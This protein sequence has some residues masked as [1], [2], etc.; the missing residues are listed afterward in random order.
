MRLQNSCKVILALILLCTAAWCADETAKPA[1]TVKQSDGRIDVN[2]ADQPFAAYVYKDEKI[3]RPY[4]TAVHAPNGVQVTRNHP[5][6][7]GQDDTDHDTMHP[8]IWQAFGDLGGADFWR[9]KA[10]VKHQGFVVEP[11]A[12]PDYALFTVEN[13]YVDGEKLIA[14]EM[15]RY[16]LRVDELGYY[17]LIDSTFFDGTDAFTFGD[18]EEMGLGVRVA[19]PMAVKNGGTLLNSEGGKDEA[20]V[21]GKSAAWCDYS[22]VIDGKPVGITLMPNPANF[23]PSWFHARDYGFFAANP[24]GRNAM[25]GGE[26]SAIEVKLGETFEVGYG[27][28]IHSG[29][30]A[31]AELPAK[32]YDRYKRMTASTPD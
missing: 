17:L 12:G 30:T 4:W 21:W 22:G 20:G 29:D 10:Q 26:K 25:T 1:V 16:T 23:R 28:F 3:P 18:Q 19:T 14:R 8:G 32:A 24:F 6:V 11:N 7:E 15:C 5:P 9:N 2:V 27:V 13:A 31:D